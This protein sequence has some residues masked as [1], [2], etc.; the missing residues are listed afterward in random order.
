MDR[1]PRKNTCL[2]RERFLF[3]AVIVMMPYHIR[4]FLDPRRRWAS[5]FNLASSG[6]P[7]NSSS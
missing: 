4:H 7:E 3:A 5:K 6:L 2:E 1:P